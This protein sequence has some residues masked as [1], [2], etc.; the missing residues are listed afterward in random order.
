VYNHVAEIRIG[1]ETVVWRGEHPVSGRRVT[2]KEPAPNLPAADRPRI[3]GQL[4]REYR[5]LEQLAHD[6]IVKVVQWDE[7]V[8]RMVLED[9]QGSLHQLLAREGRL[10]ADLVARVMAECLHGLTYLHDRTL[11]HG[12]LCTWSVLLGP[13]CDIRLGDFTGYRSDQGQPPVPPEYVLKYKAPE[14][15][16]ASAG[17]DPPEVRAARADLYALGF[18]GCE[19]LAGRMFD[20]LIWPDG[21]PLSDDDA[22]WLGWHADAARTLPP[23]EKVLPGV[24]RPMLAILS[25][26]TQKDPARRPFKSARE[27]LAALDEARQISARKLPPLDAGPARKQ[28]TAPARPLEL[29]DPDPLPAPDGPRR[30]VVVSKPTLELWEDGALV[31]AARFRPARPGVIGRSPR[32]RLRIDDPAVSDKHA[33]LACQDTGRWW[34]YDLI[35]RTGV[36]VGGQAVLAAPLTDGAEVT[37]GPRRFRVRLNPEP[38]PAIGD[39]EPVKLLHTGQ[40]GAKLYLARWRLDGRSA[41]V[42]VFPP[43]FGANTEDVQRFLRGIPEAGGL[44]HPHLVALYRG[45]FV[46]PEPDTRTWFLATEYLPG[47]SLRDKLREAGRPLPVDFVVRFAMDIARALEVVA[48]KGLVH[49]NVNPS[50]ILFGADGA[51]KLG[52]FFLLRDEVVETLNQITKAGVPNGEYPYQPPEQLTGSKVLGPTTDLYSL[53]A[54]MYHAL[55]LRP[56]FNPNQPLLKLVD[57]IRKEP[58]EPIRK[59]NLAVPEALENLILSALD[60]QLTRWPATPTDMLQALG[61]VPQPATPRPVPRG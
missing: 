4:L 16:Q 60:K 28:P 36:R 22:D 23:L 46:T 57:Q 30:V 37:I 11:A 54:C 6:R 18:L 42:R 51:A 3:A 40:E 10:E 44:R 50:C 43:A 21:L 27:V 47:G 35:S 32:S 20:Q 2:V 29:P 48:G 17:S 8:G 52:D 34:V 49:R 15:L 41:A 13:G 55:T 24:P 26:L 33:L 19:S 53:A 25:G 59:Y 9:T 39:F 1:R 7:S 12:C 56:P 58:V 5:F 61:G 14:L 38:I 45:G 31:H